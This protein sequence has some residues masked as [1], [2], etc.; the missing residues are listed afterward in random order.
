MASNDTGAQQIVEV[1]FN[2]LYADVKELAARRT[3]GGLTPV[4]FEPATKFKTFFKR[5]LALWA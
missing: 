4:R 1:A 2:Y 5:F 3:R